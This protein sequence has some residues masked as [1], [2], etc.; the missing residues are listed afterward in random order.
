MI[1]YIKVTEPTQPASLSLLLA[2]PL[3][4]VTLVAMDSGCLIL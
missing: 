2:F 4:S 3:I 1:A